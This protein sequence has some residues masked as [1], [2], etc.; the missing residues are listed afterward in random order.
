MNCSKCDKIFYLRAS[1]TNCNCVKC[2]PIHSIDVVLL[3]AT[4]GANYLTTSLQ[5]E[6]KL[7]PTSPTGMA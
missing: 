4:Q 7:K 3:V 1:K 5:R 2:V 6:N